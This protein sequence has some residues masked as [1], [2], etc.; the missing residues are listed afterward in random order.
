MCA[1]LVAD[2]KS[3]TQLKVLAEK[4]GM[5]I[6]RVRQKLGTEYYVKRISNLKNF[7]LKDFLDD[8]KSDM[9]Q[10][11]LQT[12]YKIDPPI[13]RYLINTYSSADTRVRR[14]MVTRNTRKIPSKSKIIESLKY[15]DSLEISTYK[16]YFEYRRNS[17]FSERRKLVSVTAILS[18]F[19]TWSNA[20][21]EA[22]L[23]VNYGRPKIN[24]SIAELKNI[25]AKFIRYCKENSI[26]T[27][28]DQF[29]LW[30]TYKNAGISSLPF[31]H[32]LRTHYGTEMT[33]GEFLL[34]DS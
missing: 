26:N 14:L 10:V 12:K 17:K 4:Y 23:T 6:Y 5:S 9:T 25:K 33:L 19:R 1:E 16:G 28:T 34:N 13:I 15:A 32:E 27:T 20:R 11:E 22:G 30:C 29:I 31:M 8:L 3:G 18:I 7:K 24:T 2:Y 21:K